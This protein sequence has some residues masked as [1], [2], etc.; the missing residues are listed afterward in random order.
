MILMRATCTFVSLVLAGSLAAQAASQPVPQ[1]FPKPASQ[2]ATTPP[3][4]PPATSQPPRPAA[5][6]PA[7][8]AAPAPV[9]V[10]NEATLGVPVY[11][12]A[13][14]IASYDAGSGQRY[15]LF[16]VAGSFMDLVNY[17]R[18]VLKNRGELVYEEPPVHMFDTGRFREES[19][20]FPPSVTVKDYT[21]GGSKGYLVPLAGGKAQR[22]PSIIQVVPVP[23]AER[24]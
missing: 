3:P 23:P 2:P 14:F 10:P 8:A 18:T 15:Y 17:Y 22:Y 7:P 1:P 5:P 21:W 20:A 4:P 9:A 12:S 24:R 16:G 19:M 13:Q 11:P 6:P